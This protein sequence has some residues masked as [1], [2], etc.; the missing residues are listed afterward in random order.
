MEPEQKSSCFLETGIAVVLLVHS[1]ASNS[2]LIKCEHIYL[3]VVG[4]CITQCSGCIPHAGV[5][6]GTTMRYSEHAFIMCPS[7]IAKAKDPPTQGYFEHTMWSS[8]SSIATDNIATTTA[9]T[10]CVVSK[11]KL[12]TLPLPLPSRIVSFQRPNFRI[13]CESKLWLDYMFSQLVVMT[14]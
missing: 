7:S 3:L 13:C 8:P 14:T 6:E 1:L 9:L 12:T 5:K 10:H 4:S 11:T 2:L